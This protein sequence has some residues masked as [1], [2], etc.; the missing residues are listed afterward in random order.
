MT[1][2]VNNLFN[3]DRNLTNSYL[4]VWM[5]AITTDKIKQQVN[6]NN[7][8]EVRV[9][10]GNQIGKLI[11]LKVGLEVVTRTVDVGNEINKWEPFTY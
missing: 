4:N 9:G 10:N 1:R 6:G 8:K 3:V 11:Y 7:S 2:T 5:L